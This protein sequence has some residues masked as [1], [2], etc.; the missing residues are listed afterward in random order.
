MANRRFP[1]PLLLTL[2]LCLTATALLLDGLRGERAPTVQFG[3]L[4]VGPVS[5]TSLRGHPVIVNFWATTCSVCRRELPH[6][7]ELY[8]ELHPRGLEL[9]GVAMPYDPPNLVAEYVQRSSLP[10]PVA[11][12]IDGEIVETFGGVA[13]TPTTFL[14]S[15]EGII[16]RRVEGRINFPGLRRHI[17]ALL[18]QVRPDRH[19]HPEAAPAGS[20]AQVARR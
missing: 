10:Y 1:L 16:V 18:P 4:G 5:M 12:D 8:L 2:M 20:T 7:A 3:V 9:I 11:L 14:I 15:P 19:G 13:A 17:L 6:L